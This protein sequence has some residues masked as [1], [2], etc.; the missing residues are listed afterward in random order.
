MASSATD[1][2]ELLKQC[3]NLLNVSHST[4]FKNLKPVLDWIKVV[5]SIHKDK[6]SVIN[7]VSFS[8]GFGNETQNRT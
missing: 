7:V 2:K 6:E 1:V 8:E 4:R 3:C 5:H